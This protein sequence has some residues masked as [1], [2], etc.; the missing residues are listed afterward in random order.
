MSSAKSLI[1]FSS[2]FIE[3]LKYANKYA[4]FF[5]AMKT[6]AMLFTK[7]LVGGSAIRLKIAKCDDELE[8][9]KIFDEIPSM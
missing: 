1:V 9:R 6:Q 4:L 3:Y 2:E 7:G 5:A 8:L